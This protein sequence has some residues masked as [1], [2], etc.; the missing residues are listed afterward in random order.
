MDTKKQTYLKN[1]GFT[2]EIYDENHPEDFGYSFKFTHSYLGNMEITVSDKNIIVWKSNTEFGSIDLAT[3]PYNKEEIYKLLI[4]F[5][6]INEHFDFGEE[7]L[8]NKKFG[9]IVQYLGN[10]MYNV[11]FNGIWE[12]HHHTQITQFHN[13]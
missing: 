11:D 3:I 7:V 10:G 8:V 4:F 5:E 9:K 2:K 1:C 13:F 12:K 6:I